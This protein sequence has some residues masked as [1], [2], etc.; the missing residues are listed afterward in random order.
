M[1]CIDVWMDFLGDV[2]WVLWYFIGFEMG[3]YLICFVCYVFWW[4]I[5]GFFFRWCVVWCGMVCV[6]WCGVVWCG[7]WFMKFCW[8]LFWCGF[9][10]V[11]SWRF[12][13]FSLFC[14]SVVGERWGEMWVNELRFFWR[15]VVF[16]WRMLFGLWECDCDDMI[17]YG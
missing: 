4:F 8:C 9:F 13:G 6:V 11:V 15:Y 2:F 1:W 14:R 17:D 16:V 7:V 3:V 5:C 10:G 12:G